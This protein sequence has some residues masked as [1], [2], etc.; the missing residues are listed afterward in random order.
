MKPLGLTIISLFDFFLTINLCREWD[1][2]VGTCFKELYVV[3]S[4]TL[5]FYTGIFS[6]YAS[7]SHAQEQRVGA[8]HAFQELMATAE[9]R[10]REERH[11]KRPRLNAW[12]GYNNPDLEILRKGIGPES[13]SALSTLR[14]IRT[15]SIEEGKLDEEDIAEIQ[16]TRNEETEDMLRF[17]R[18]KQQEQ[19]ANS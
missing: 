15:A 5:N 8:M 4:H 16:R 1:S 6:S 11:E 14:D 7:Y 3:K 17:V 2:M 19:E 18:E 10:N 13:L 12:G 9:R